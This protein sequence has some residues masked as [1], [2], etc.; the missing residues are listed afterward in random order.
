MNDPAA[1]PDRSEYADFYHTYVG[2]VP[3]GSILDTLSAEITAVA[4]LLAPVSDELARSRYA[5]GKWSVKEVMGHV[6]D[7]ERVFGFRAMSFARGE[8]QEIPGMEQDHYVREGRFDDVPLADL[9]AEFCHAR[10]ANVRMI[11]NFSEEAWMRR[12]TASGCEFTVR[13]QAWILAAHALHHRR[14]LTERYLAV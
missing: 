11:R 3:D 10:E 1:R 14:F 9:A 5:P 7:V 4:D 12:G 2:K 6:A 13:A 8:R